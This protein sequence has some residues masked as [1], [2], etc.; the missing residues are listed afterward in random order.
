MAAGVIH[1]Y[2]IVCPF[3]DGSCWWCI[4]PR[5]DSLLPFP[6]CTQISS[7][8]QIPASSGQHPYSISDGKSHRS[9]RFRICHNETTRKDPEFQCLD[10]SQQGRAAAVARYG[11]IWRAMCE[12]RPGKANFCCCG[13]LYRPSVYRSQGEVP[14]DSRLIFPFAGSILVSRREQLLL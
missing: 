8:E 3:G 5:F 14:I 6:S 4:P 11:S 12:Q 9:A 2:I 7:R 1:G 13:W 10:A